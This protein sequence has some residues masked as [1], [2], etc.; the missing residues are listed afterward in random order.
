VHDVGVELARNGAMG[1]FA[2]DFVVSRQ[3]SV[4][5]WDVYGL[6]INLR[7]GGTTHTLGVVRLLLDLSR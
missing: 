5:S 7:K 6:E 2:V 4:D 1:R 3:S